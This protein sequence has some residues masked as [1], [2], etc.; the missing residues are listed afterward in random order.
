MWNSSSSSS[1]RYCDGE[2]DITT[3]KEGNKNNY[4]KIGLIFLGL[5]LLFVFFYWMFKKKNP[6]ICPASSRKATTYTSKSKMTQPISSSSSSSSLPYNKTGPTYTKSF[7]ENIT[8]PSPLPPMNNNNNNNN[9]PIGTFGSLFPSSYPAQPINVVP[10]TYTDAYPGPLNNNN[11]IPIN[12]VSFCAGGNGN[13][14]S[15]SIP[16]NTLTSGQF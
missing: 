2:F 11:N 12:P 9:N 6:P 16:F 5:F 15:E 13:G 14:N 1:D 8:T 3:S 7:V 4:L 10:P